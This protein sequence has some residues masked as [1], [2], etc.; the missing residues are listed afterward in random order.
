MNLAQGLRFC[1]VLVLFTVV[2]AFGDEKVTPEQHE[3]RLFIEKMY[4]YDPDSFD[5]GRFSK[6]D[7]SPFTRNRVPKEGGGFEPNKKCALLRE[8]F[9]ESV[10]Q[11][12]T[13]RPGLVGCDVINLRYP[14]LAPEDAPSD[15]RFIRIPPPK[16]KTPIING[17]RAKISVYTEGDRISLGLSLYFLTKSDNGWKISNVMIVRRFPEPTDERPECDYDFAKKPSAEELKEVPAGCR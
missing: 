4:S 10:I 15:I 5:N 9:D 7:G 13:I 14:N 1:A 11:K 17:N 8:F 16:I 3:V 12:R 2:S 6:K